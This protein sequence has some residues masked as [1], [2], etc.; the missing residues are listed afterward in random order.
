MSVD[1]GPATDDDDLA[2]GLVGRDGGPQPGG[3]RANHE[4]VGCSR[5]GYDVVDFTGSASVWVAHRDA[6]RDAGAL[7]WR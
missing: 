6:A 1:A 7:A 3:A 5:A 4:D 2:T